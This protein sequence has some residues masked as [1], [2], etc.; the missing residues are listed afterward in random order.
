MN[1]RFSYF[2]MILIDMIKS[3]NE[4]RAKV[5]IISIEYKTKSKMTKIDIL[6]SFN[7]LSLFYII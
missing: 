7:Y 1:I 2:R 3:L 5:Y 4:C 6:Y